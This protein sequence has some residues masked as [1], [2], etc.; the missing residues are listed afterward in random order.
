[1]LRQLFLACIA[2][3]VILTA[4][5]VRSFIY[6]RVLSDKEWSFIKHWKIAVL[7]SFIIAVAFFLYLV[8]TGETHL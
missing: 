2:F 8:V 3:S 7:L 5:A 4:I 6:E 1:M